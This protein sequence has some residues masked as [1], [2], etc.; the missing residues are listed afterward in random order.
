MRTG[1]CGAFGVAVGA[2]GCRGMP[3][4]FYVSM[5]RVVL[6]V[7]LPVVFLLVFLV[8]ILVVFHVVLGWGSAV[9]AC[10]AWARAIM[11]AGSISNHM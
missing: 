6:L 8:M 4:G 1:A 7:V 5:L 10:S 2:S 3:R 9:P 11:V